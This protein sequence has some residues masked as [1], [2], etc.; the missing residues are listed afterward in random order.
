MGRVGPMEVGRLE[1]K[2]CKTISVDGGLSCIRPQ[3][4]VD[5]VALWYEYRI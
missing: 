5:L 2:D 3:S 4:I 1:A